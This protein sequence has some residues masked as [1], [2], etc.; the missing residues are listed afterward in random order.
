MSGDREIRLTVKALT[1]ILRRGLR[2][3]AR[4]RSPRALYQVFSFLVCRAAGRARPVNAFITTTNRCQCRCAHCYTSVGTDRKTQELPTGEI[5]SI[6]DQLKAIGTLQVVFTGGEPLL[7][8]DIYELIAYAHRIGLLTRI[9]TNGYKLDRACA[10]RLKEAGLDQCGISI[11]YIDA[12]SHDRFRVLKG[13]HAR[14]LQAFGYLHEAGILRRM[15]VFTTRAKLAAG[16]E[17]FVELGENLRLNSVFFSV[18]YAVGNWDGAYGEVLSEKE[19]GTLRQL[20]K[21]PSVAM[22]FTTPQTNC[23]VY[24]KTLLSINSAGDVSACPAVPFSL[25]NIHTE[26]LTA[27]WQRHASASSPESRG[28]CPMNSPEGREQMQSYCAKA[29]IRDSKFRIRD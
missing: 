10:S 14:A 7:R 9:N 19:M 16:L 17:R 24:D 27:I 22:E 26:S 21:Y 6:L 4:N 18:P 12:E 13:L 25:G 2:L 11:D 23:L 5:L 1:N 29:A 28:K 3:Y 8:S 20:Q 15:Y